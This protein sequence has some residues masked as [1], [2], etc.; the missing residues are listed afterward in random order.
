M[1]GRVALVPWADMLNHSCDVDTFLDYDNLSKGIVFTTDRPYQPGEQVFISYG[2]KSNGELLLSYGFVPREGANSCDSIELSVSLKKS[3]KSYKEK[4][5]LLKKYGLSGSQCF[6]IQITGWPL[7][8]MAYA[9]L[10]VS[11]P[12]M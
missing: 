8:L 5:E 10:A 9:Y 11:P 2:K 1:D 7:E 4:L 6:P 3:D 12:N